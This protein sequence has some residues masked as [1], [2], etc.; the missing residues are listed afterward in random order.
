MEIMRGRQ[1][2][3]EKIMLYGVG[4]IGKSS[5]V[6]MLENMVFMQAED[7]LRHIDC[8]KIP[9]VKDWDGVLAQLKWVATED[10]DFKA[11]AIDTFDS[12]ERIIWDRVCADEEKSSIE[13]IGYG[14]GYKFALAY[15]AKL[16]K[17]LEYI[18]AKRNM[19]IILIGHSAV[20]RFDDP[21]GDSYD[22]YTPKLHRDAMAMLQEW[23]NYILFARYKV[24]TKSA[25]DGF[26]ENKKKAI[27]QAERILLTRPR[28]THIA[29]SSSTTLPEELPLT[30]KFDWTNFFNLINGDTKW[31]SE[32]TTTT[33]TQTP[34][35]SPTEPTK[36]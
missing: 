2:G 16:I 17:G 12:L 14:K 33:S 28:P 23:V 4:G 3:P 26:N 29:K 30:L 24:I 6:A 32:T 5:V 34:Q 35:Q 8:N 36:S 25:G 31:T 11:F 10:H 7:R 13:K 22:F 9:V 15:W 1:A 19:H 21:A 20:Q 18:Q 27:G